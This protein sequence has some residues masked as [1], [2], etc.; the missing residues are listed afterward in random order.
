MCVCVCV[1][2][3]PLPDPYRGLYRNPE[4]AGQQYADEVKKII[5][6][7]TEQGKKVL[8][9]VV[10]SDRLSCKSS[11]DLCVILVDNHVTC[12]VCVSST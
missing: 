8:E 10:S 4:T 12:G 6:R 1:C 9:L 2:K 7:A 5:D 11:H 3:A